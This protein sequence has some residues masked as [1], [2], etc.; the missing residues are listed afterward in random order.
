MWV[1][2]YDRLL[3]KLELTGII[4]VPLDTHGAIVVTVKFTQNKIIYGC[5][6]LKQDAT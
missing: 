6:N 3:L 2:L 4:L 1:P 5:C